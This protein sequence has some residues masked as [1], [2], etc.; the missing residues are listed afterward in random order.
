MKRKTIKRYANGGTV[1]NKINAGDVLGL[2]SGF[3]NPVSA[4]PSALGMIQKLTYNPASYTPARMNESPRGY[5]DGGKPGDPRT[6]SVPKVK[7]YYEKL[8]ASPFYERVLKEQGATSKTV[9][10][11]LRNNLGNRTE[12]MPVELSNKGG[13][14][15]YPGNHKIKFGIEHTMGNNSDAVLAHEMA[16]AVTGG[17]KDN[18]DYGSYFNRKNI[19]SKTSLK[20]KIHSGNAEELRADL[21]AVRFMLHDSGNWDMSRNIN[22]KDLDNLKSHPKYKNDKIFKRTLNLIDE[23]NKFNTDKKSN[24]R[25]LELLNS[26]VTTDNKSNV[27]YAAYGADLQ[28]KAQVTGGN[29]IEMGEHAT[30]IQ[31]N[32]GIDTNRRN[33]GGQ[34]VALTKG[35]IVRQD[36][37]GSSYIWSNNPKMLHPS[38]KTFAQAMKPIENKI[39]NIKRRINRDP[40][41]NIASNTLGHLEQMIE[42]NKNIEESMRQAKGSSTAMKFNQGGY[43]PGYYEGGVIKAKDGIK[44]KRDADPNST[45]YG[46]I[47][48]IEGELINNDAMDVITSSALEKRFQNP[49][50]EGF[51]NYSFV[52]N[53]NKNK[54]FPVSPTLSRSNSPFTNPSNFLQANPSPLTAVKGS[55]PTPQE[56]LSTFEDKAFMG[57]KALET[58]FRVGTAMQKPIQYDTRRY[59]VDKIKYNANKVLDVN[60]RNYQGSQFD[61]NT[62]NANTDRILRN[63][64]Y[65]QKSAAD[66]DTMRQYDEMQRNSDLQVN[67]YNA[68]SKANIDN[69]NEQIRGRQ[70]QAVDAAASSVGNLASIFQQAGAAKTGNKISLATLNSLSKRYGIDMSNLMDM[71][72]GK[73]DSSKG[74]IKYKGK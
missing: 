17:V 38:G 7:S 23:T 46:A 69:I 71:I 20:D 6:E 13:S 54:P 35:E 12:T 2:A 66:R 32:S 39:A 43:V 8:Y 51:E 16:H 59:N 48:G 74:T 63:N 49:L 50:R 53:R 41:D 68:Q 42:Q 3:I 72:D 1:D 5:A 25:A 37:D 31:G 40:S 73:G 18:I 27:A 56:N 21:N 30:Q 62:G 52:Q 36:G 28:N 57:T 55:T 10:R 15:Y 44:I 26:V 67:Q 19:N 64:L 47:V 11:R 22:Q 29:D 61:I 70:Y 58:A 9:N 33:V 4:I 45:N 65:S 34:E 24:Q 14:A 60:E